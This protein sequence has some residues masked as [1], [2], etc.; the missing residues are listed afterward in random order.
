MKHDMSPEVKA[1]ITT[2][3]NHHAG[4][5]EVLSRPKLPSPPPKQVLSKPPIAESQRPEALKNTHTPRKIPIPRP[6]V[7]LWD[8]A[9][10]VHHVL[11]GP[12]HWLGRGLFLAAGFGVLLYM[13]VVVTIGVPFG[14]P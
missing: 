8:E 7:S 3:P 12:H 4:D 13:W 6:A 5:P 9:W 1:F 11:L 2:N 10:G 14:V